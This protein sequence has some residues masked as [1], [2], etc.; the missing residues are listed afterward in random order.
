MN[1]YIQRHLTMEN[2][3]ELPNGAVRH[4]TQKTTIKKHNGLFDFLLDDKIAPYKEIIRWCNFFASYSRKKR[5]LP[6]VAS[7]I[8][9]RGPKRKKAIK[10]LLEI[11]G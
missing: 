9:A 6:Q 1:V 3:D 4:Y 2:I 5:F 11:T 10:L 7:L 8:Q